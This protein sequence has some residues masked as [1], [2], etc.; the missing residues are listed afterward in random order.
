MVISRSENEM[1]LTKISNGKEK[2]Y[3]DVAEEKGETRTALSKRPY[4]GP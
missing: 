4:L 1:Y 3:A 2:I